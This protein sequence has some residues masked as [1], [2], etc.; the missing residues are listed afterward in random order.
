V[1]PPRSSNLTEAVAKDEKKSSPWKWIASIV[2]LVSLFAS[3]RLLPVTQWLEAF[4]EWVGNLGP[5]GI[6]IFIGAYVL[7]TVL[8]LPGSVLTIGA[9]FVFG[10]GWGLFAVSIGSTLGAASAFLISRFIARERVEAMALE[11]ESFLRIDK[12]IGAQGAKLILLLRLSPLIPFNLSNYFYGLTAVKFWPYVFAS[13]IGMLPG[14][15]LYV[16]LGAAGKAGLQAASGA[17]AGRS[18]L[19]WTFLGFGLVATIA[20]TVWVTKIA[21]TALRDR[22]VTEEPRR[23][24]CTAP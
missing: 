5:W 23:S 17:D 19:E 2:V 21:R 16:Y 1:N 7:A 14:T 3:A 22:N 15:L 24:R 4:S 18:P 13:W 12:A 9:G 8:L 6:A 10:L 20:V 11:N